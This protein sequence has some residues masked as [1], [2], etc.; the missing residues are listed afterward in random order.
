MPQSDLAFKPESISHADA[1]SI[2]LV[3]LAAFQA[4]QDIA[5][6]QAG[7]KVLVHGGAG[8]LGSIAIQIAKHFGHMS[9]LHCGPRTLI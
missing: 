5:H 8:G 4:L 3:G 6:I 1:A 7:Q 9:Q 2:P